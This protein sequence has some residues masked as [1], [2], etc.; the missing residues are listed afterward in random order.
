MT[1]LARF[2][3]AMAAL[4]MVVAACPRRPEPAPEPVATGPTQ[5]QLDSI[6]R[7]RARLDSISRAEQAR[8]DSIARIESMRADSIRRAQEAMAGARNT[9]SG[10]I[11]YELDSSDLTAQAQAALDAKLAILRANPAVRLRVSGHADERG[12]DEYNLA[13]GQRRAAAAKR[14]LTQRGVDGTRIE[15]ASFGEERPAADGHDE[16][17]WSQNRR[18]EFEIIAGGDMIQSSGE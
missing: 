2:A 7:E 6:A 15:T 12:G 5:A 18:A 4:V 1:R 9:L 8:R 17:A 11:Y 16:S 3:P 14:Y 10:V 13:L